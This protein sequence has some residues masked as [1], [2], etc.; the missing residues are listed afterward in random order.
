ME[1]VALFNL[2]HVVASG[3]AVVRG[4]APER[5]A[6]VAMLVATLA[7]RLV[8][9]QAAVRFAGVE[10]GVFCVDVA[11]L[12]ILLAVALEADRYWPLWMAALQGLGTTAHL[13]KLLEVELLRP[14]Y[15][16]LAAIWSYP[17]LVLLF[18]GALRHHLRQRR[19]GN[20]RAWSR[21]L[22]S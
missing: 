22:L 7:T 21:S 16:V 14:A 15:A 9:S 2:L 1:R 3:Y 18:C 13:S 10:W 11:L 5:I 8:Q 17:M 19:F 20:D 12:A 4:G 6:G